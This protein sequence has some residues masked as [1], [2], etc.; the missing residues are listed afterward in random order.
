[1]AIALGTL[2]LG[3]THADTTLNYTDS[4]RPNGTEVVSITA[5]GAVFRADH[6]A[7]LYRADDEALVFIDHQNKTFTVMDD[8]RAT[9]VR[10]NVVAS[11]NQLAAVALQ[12]LKAT[13]T[14]DSQR[15]KAK[16]ILEQQGLDESGN[17]LPAQR[18]SLEA[19]GASTVNERECKLLTVRKGGRAFQKVCVVTP[20][21]IAMPPADYAMMIRATNTMQARV[22]R[23]SATSLNDE[24]MDMAQ[25]G[26]V[27]ILFSSLTGSSNKA[28]VSH[29]TASVD[30]AEMTIPAGYTQR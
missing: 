28:L 6:R 25:L 17:D 20:A 22:S 23:L 29:S 8:A 30:P 18:M 15:E 14:S 24:V 10:A 1:M 11:R 13:D 7:V 5:E 2:C 16:K 26:G 9:A 27:P 12:M 3:S 19:S 4:S 21:S